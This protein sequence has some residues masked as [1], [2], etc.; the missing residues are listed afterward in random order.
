M[1]DQENRPAALVEAGQRSRHLAGALAVQAARG[2]VRQQQ[3]R[4]V[5]QGPGERQPPLL[6]AGQL[7][8][9]QPCAPGRGRWRRR[10]PD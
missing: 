7:P 3:G 2:L 4:M 10:P 8:G 6:A 9:Q 5:D 1:G